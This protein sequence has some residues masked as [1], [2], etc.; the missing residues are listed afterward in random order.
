MD[1][2]E[3][4]RDQLP[5]LVRYAGVLTADS[6]LAQDL[7][8]DALVRAHAGWARIGRLDRPDLY[9]RHMITNGYLSWRRRWATRSVRRVA[10]A[11][12]LDRA[13]PDPADRLADR[14]Q[15]AAL[16]ATLSRRQR[17]V[18]VLRF[19]EGRSDEEIGAILGCTAVTV[20]SHV[21]RALAGLRQRAGADQ[22][23]LSES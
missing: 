17:A 7:T 11:A 3:F 10:E 19:Y 8:Q 2:D 4:L 21:S 23:E 14:D 16:L 5:A 6:H 13:V 15:L 18:L 22:L 1:F 9:V 20:R 12:L